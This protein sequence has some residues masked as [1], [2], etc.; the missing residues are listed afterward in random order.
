MLRKKKTRKLRIYTLNVYPSGSTPTLI[1]N[2]K[3]KEPPLNMP[4]E[5]SIFMTWLTSKYSTLDL[6]TTTTLS[7]RLFTDH[8]QEL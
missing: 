7:Q 4:M 5:Y 6:C 1:D 8:K 3:N 2:S